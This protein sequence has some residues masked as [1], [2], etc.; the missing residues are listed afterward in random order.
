MREDESDSSR[1]DDEREEIALFDP[2]ERHFVSEKR[3]NEFR[4]FLENDRPLRSDR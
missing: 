1:R 4:Q 2:Y 3:K